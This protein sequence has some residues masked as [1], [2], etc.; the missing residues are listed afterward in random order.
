MT[1]KGDKRASIDELAT[2]L[3][4][5]EEA[6]ARRVPRTQMEAAFAKRWG[7]SE[8]TVRR[9]TQLVREKWR[10]EAEGED[11]VARR[12]AMRASLNGIFNKAVMRVTVV[13]DANGQPIVDP[14]TGN[15]IKVE[16]PDLRAAL[17]ASRVLIQLDG[18]NDEA[19]PLRVDLSG[20]VTHQASDKDRA[21]LEAFL[22]GRG[23]KPTG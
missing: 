6:M 19:P 2:R 22:L 5:V 8:R 11:R 7:C 9:Y 20:T 16:N 1:R 3:R 18:L 21:A 4:E 13:R 17:H 14:T 12:D 15:P 10:K 23:A